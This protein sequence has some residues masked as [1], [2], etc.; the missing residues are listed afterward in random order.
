MNKWFTVA[1]FFGCL[2]GSMEAQQET[3]MPASNLLTPWGDPDL[4]GIWTN[5]TST[6]FE[7]PSEFGE[8]EFLTD[9]E[10]AQKQQEAKQ[11][12]RDAIEG[13]QT[14]VA[15]GPEHWYEHLGKTSNRT[16]HVI[17]PP[18]GKVPALT[19]EAQ[20]RPVKGTMHREYFESWE[21]LSA[22]DRCITRSVP[23]SMLPSFYNNN[24]QILQTPDFVVIF[25]EMIHD[26]RFIAL[27]NQP[28]L[29][30]NLRQ[31]MGDSRGHWEGNTLVVEVLNFTNQTPLHPV[32][33]EASK[34]NH[35]QNLKV[36]ER[37][38]RINKET[39][40]YRFTVDDPSTFMQPWSAAIPMTTNDAPDAMFEYA[41][42]EGNH[43]L[44]HILSASR[45]QDAKDEGVSK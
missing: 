25:Y 17:D 23:G 3:K 5:T 37:F 22:W 1:I 9:E 7:R 29:P 42:H 18:N 15:S 33:G 20:Q 30:E 45:A 16:S 2:A 19:A 35:S 6:P 14:K 4:R 31:W 21:D 26:I 10:F 27:N 12:E 43:A 38:T 11:Q 13:E 24:Y 40:D 8:R 32:R 28:R 44:G 34:V 36:I 41:C 39:I